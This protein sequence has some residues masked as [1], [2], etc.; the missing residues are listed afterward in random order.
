[1]HENSPCI[2]P[3]KSATTINQRATTHLK[4]ALHRFNNYPIFGLVQWIHA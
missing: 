1:M 2:T 4:D 3:T